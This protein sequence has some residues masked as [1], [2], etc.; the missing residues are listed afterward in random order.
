[1]REKVKIYHGKEIPNEIFLKINYISGIRYEDMYEDINTLEEL[2]QSYGTKPNEISIILGEDWYIIYAV[3]KLYIEIIE[4]YS[5]ETVKDKF[6]QI[7]EMFKTLKEILLSSNGRRIVAN[8]KLSTS[9]KFY[10]IFLEKGYFKELSSFFGAELPF[11]SDEDE[12]IEKI[13]PKYQTIE[14]YLEDQ[15]REPYSEYERYFYCEAHFTITEKFKKRYKTKKPNRR[16][17]N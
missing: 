17:S 11:S 14:E 15:Y 7:M 4:W 9:Y 1:M 3:K 12:L 2:C 6:C 10:R 5:I 13:T 16:S 8:M